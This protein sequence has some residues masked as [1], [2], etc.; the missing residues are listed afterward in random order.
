A[1]ELSRLDTHTQPSGKRINQSSLEIPKES[2]GTQ[3]A[4]IKHPVHAASTSNRAFAAFDLGLQSPRSIAS[5]SRSAISRSAGA[6]RPIPHNNFSI[7]SG[8]Y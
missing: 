7:S 3:H 4:L 8:R 2:L 5:P 1:R 6:Q